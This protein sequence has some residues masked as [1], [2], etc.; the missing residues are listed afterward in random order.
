[1]RRWRSGKAGLARPYKNA[2]RTGAFL[3]CS[4]AICRK[5]ESLGTKQGAQ[6]PVST[7]RLTKAVS[8]FYYVKGQTL[9]HM[10]RWRSGKAGLARPYKNAQ[11]TGAFLCCSHAICRKQESLG[12]KQGAQLPVSTKRLTKAVSVFYYVKGQTLCH[13]RRWRSGKAGLARIFAC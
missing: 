13:M 6:L 11:R 3:C 7:K 2:Q 9:C 12:T 10:R 5:Q 4:H 8:V 1:M